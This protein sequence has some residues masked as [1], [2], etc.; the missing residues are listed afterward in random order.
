MQQNLYSLPEWNF[1]GG[2]TQTRTWTLYLPNG[3]VQDVSNGKASLAIDSYINPTGSPL[4]SKVVDVKE[5]EEGNFCLITFTL[6][7]QDT[8]D[9]EGVY[10]YTLTIKQDGYTAIPYRGMMH[11]A[12]NINKG[13]I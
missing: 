5:D 11:I 12:A 10:F 8:V 2:S 13:F 3:G 4:I 9:M 7:P 1:I 6:D